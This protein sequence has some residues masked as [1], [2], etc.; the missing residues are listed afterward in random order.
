MA[1]FFSAV[2]VAFFGR[3]FALG[4][5]TNTSMKSIDDDAERDRSVVRAAIVAMLWF[6]AVGAVLASIGGSLP[7]GRRA[8]TAFGLLTVVTVGAIC[9]GAVIGFIF[10]IPRALQGAD[11]PKTNGEPTQLINTN[12][13]Q[14]SDWLTKIIVGVSLVQ[15]QQIFVTLVKASERLG[16]GFIGFDPN[17]ATGIVALVVVAGFILGFLAMYIETRTFLSPMFLRTAKIEQ[18]LSQ[19][20]IDRRLIKDVPAASID[21]KPPDL[22]PDQK[23]AIDR[24]A[25]QP[26]ATAKT[27]EELETWAKARFLQE[28]YAAAEQ[29]YAQALAS[30]PDDYKTRRQYGRVLVLAGK[31]EPGIAELDRAREAAAKAK[32]LATAQRLDLDRV[33]ARLYLPGDGFQKAVE[34]GKQLITENPALA[35]DARLQTYMACAYGQEYAL[36]SAQEE[37]EAADGAAQAAKD[38]INKVI[39]A[40]AGEGW[41]QFLRVLASGTSP[42]DDDLAVLAKER[43]E[44]WKIIDDATRR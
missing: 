15:A 13:E 28:D 44:I 12:L 38:A 6:L 34:L 10:G 23:A 41:R 31:P 5:T 42:N 33:W 30:R 1:R 26:M 40:P 8:V 2:P 27:P 32:D 3:L 9:C 29:G 24:V 4:G 39:A 17:L 43:P 11:V 35:S 14:I 19:L 36:H 16:K 25:A 22:S 37:A 21:A 18:S 7:H 20:E